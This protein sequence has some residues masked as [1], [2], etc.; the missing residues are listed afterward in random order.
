MKITSR[1]DTNAEADGLRTGPSDLGA[2]LDLAGEPADAGLC[3]RLTRRKMAAEVDARKLDDVLLVVSELVAN[4]VLHAATELVFRVRLADASLTVSVDDFDSTTGFGPE[5][6]HKR[7]AEGRGLAIVDQLADRW[8]I[9][10]VP[11][12][13]RVWARFDLP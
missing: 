1:T 4:G 12:G 8:G 9:T 11:G 13:K 3:R 10:V 2:S 5:P 7:S 6:T